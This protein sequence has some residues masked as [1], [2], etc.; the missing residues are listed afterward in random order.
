MG[1]VSFRGVRTD[2][3]GMYI[4][5]GGMLEYKKAKQRHIEYDIPGRD[6]AVHIMDG[7]G[8]F[9]LKVMLQM[10][11]ATADIRRVVNAWADGSGDLYS[12]DDTTQVWK[13]S[14]LKEVKYSRLEYNGL[15]YDTATVTFRCQPIRRERVPEVLT[16]TE[17]KV[18]TNPGNVPA[19]PK[20]EV[21]GTGTCM[22]VIGGETISIDNVNGS[23]T[24]D[25]ETGYIFAD[26][27]AV[28]MTGEF[29]VLGLGDTLLAFA[30]GVTAVKIT[31][32]WGWV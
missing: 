8:A 5:K 18:L 30:G 31:P 1:Y 27:G 13:A 2:A 12:S 28:A 3:I 19:L 7:Y 25:S 6:G 17:S 24:I 23:V 10:V 4:A 20:I 26:S 9:D 14:V 21:T 15:L 11:D 22:L 32:N 29:P 16:L